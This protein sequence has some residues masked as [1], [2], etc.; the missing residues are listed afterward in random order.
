MKTKEISFDTIQQ[1][2]KNNYT[3]EKLSEIEKL[4]NDLY[5]SYKYDSQFNIAFYN[6]K[7]NDCLNYWNEFAHYLEL[8]Q[9]ELIKNSKEL[10]K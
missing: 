3:L 1:I 8:H 7:E 4:M 2:K 6:D 10:M 5:L 9:R